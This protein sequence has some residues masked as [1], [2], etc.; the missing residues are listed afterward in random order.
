MEEK[1]FNPVVLQQK[2]ELHDALSEGKIKSSK[3]NTLD[4]YEKQFVQLVVFSGYTPI[5]AIRACMPH[6]KNP[7][8]AARRMAARADVAEVLEELTYAKKAYWM[9]Q[10][11]TERE[12]SLKKM[13][14]IRNTTDDEALAAAVSDKI[15]GRANEEL[16]K[17]EKQED[18]IT[19]FTFVINT[20]PVPQHIGSN[21]IK[22]EDIIETYDGQKVGANLGLNYGQMANQNYNNDNDE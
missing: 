12:L 13:V 1:E 17:K 5:Q 3:F 4:I 16:I 2:Q 7:A 22:P 21:N 14:H 6:I 20:A 15:W 11:E 10:L 19:G 9:S 8:P 18:A